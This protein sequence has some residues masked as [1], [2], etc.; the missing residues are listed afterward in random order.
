LTGASQRF[1]LTVDLAP[2]VVVASSNG[3]VAAFDGATF[4][5]SLPDNH[6]L[7]DNIV[8]VQITAQSHGYWLAGTNGGVFAF[9]DA[10]F[11]GSVAKSLNDPVVGIVST[12][13]DGGY[14]MVAADG[15][16][17]TFGG[18]HYYGSVPGTGTHV[19]DVVGMATTR[20]GRGYYLMTSTGAVYGFGDAHYHGGANTGRLSAP[21]VSISLDWATGGYW[22]AGAGGAVFAY[23]APFLGE[24]GALPDEVVGLAPS[25]ND[26][27]Y[28]LATRDGA[29]LPYGDTTGAAADLT[30]VVGISSS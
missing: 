6:V 28:W 24:A 7:V 15:G 14:W 12:P 5:G 13:D 10:H 25:T 3:S 27:G 26:E 22:L 18:A 20:D 30:D 9:G 17:F 11:Y 2:G 1:T 8:G 16:V 23:S 4:E 19:T 21:I 29:L